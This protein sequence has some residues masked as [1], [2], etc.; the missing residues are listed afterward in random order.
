MSGELGRHEQTGEMLSERVPAQSGRICSIE[1]SVGHDRNQWP[2]LLEDIGIARRLSSNK[3]FTWTSWGL[4]CLACSR[5]ETLINFR[6]IYPFKKKGACKIHGTLWKHHGSTVVVRPSNHLPNRRVAPAAL[7]RV[8]ARCDQA[9][10][11]EGSG[12]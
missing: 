4:D 7:P 12:D 9:G 5:N 3:Q 6:V 10:E 1:D 11:G 2:I 8:R